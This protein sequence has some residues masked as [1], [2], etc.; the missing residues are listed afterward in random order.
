MPED[1]GGLEWAN[2]ERSLKGP[3]HLGSFVCALLSANLKVAGS[4][5]I[6]GSLKIWAQCRTH[7]GLRQA[8]SCMPFT[9][10]PL[11]TPSMI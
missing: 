2:M 3:V 7:F 1:Q 6:K 9:N 10:I 5:V 4:S 8:F 11:F